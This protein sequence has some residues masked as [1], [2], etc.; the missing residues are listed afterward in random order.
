MKKISLIVLISISSYCT[1]QNLSGYVVDSLNR[2]IA[3]AS[4]MIQKIDSTYIGAVSSDTLGFFLFDRRPPGDLRLIAAHLNYIPYEM[5]V[6]DGIYDVGSLRMRGD[7]NTLSE[8]VI[9]VDRPNVIIR[10]GALSYDSKQILSQKSVSN[11]FDV[12]KETPGVIGDADRVELLGSREVKVV[13]NDNPV[14]M[15][16]EQVLM[17]LKSMPASRVKSVDIMYNAP[18]RYVNVNG[19]VINIVLDNETQKDQNVLTGEIGVEYQNQ[20]YSSGLIRTNLVYKTPRLS[21]DILANIGKGKYYSQD[22]LYSRYSISNSTFE[23]DQSSRTISDGESIDA[24][25]GVDYKLKREHNITFSYYF[26]LNNTRSEINSENMFPTIDKEDIFSLNNRDRSNQLHNALIKLYKPKKYNLGMELTYYNSPES[27]IFNEYN[28]DLIV[29]DYKNNS[30][31]EILRWIIFA[32]RSTKLKNWSINY[33]ANLGI[34]S[35]DNYVE[36]LFP[37]S[38][39]EYFEDQSKRVESKLDEITGNIFLSASGKIGNKITASATVKTEYFKTDYK[40]ADLKQT[41]WNE[42]SLF[43]S[44]TLTYN[45]SKKSIIQFNLSSSKSYPSYWAISPQSTQVNSYMIIE[46]NPELKP[47]KSYRTQLLYML[48]RKYIFTLFSAYSPDTFLQLPYQKDEV[49]IYRFENLDYTLNVGAGVVI[50]FKIGFWDSRATVQGFR[51]RQKMSNFYEKE[52]INQDF[53]VVAMLNNTFTISKSQPNIVLQAD[54]R[55]QSSAIQGIYSL[56]PAYNLS[57]SIKWTLKDGSYFIIRYNNILRQQ[58]PRPILVDWEGQYSRRVNR[59]YSSVVIAF[60]WQI[61]SYKKSNYDKVDD[62][63]FGR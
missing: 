28:N 25:V 26:N 24:R 44:A 14:S 30:S 63:R 46:G 58:T 19:A 51:M 3:F 41:L 21:L 16:N 40:L 56:G 52:F 23:V 5:V 55:Y 62:S 12:V 39:G 9:I 13:I 32:D 4:V 35:A 54:G 42:W 8:A 1:A 34:N 27:I 61:G 29:S 15:S 20:Y 37:N 57:S 49:T 60:S 11:A 50:P 53:V 45:A 6:K 48:N 33:G 59:E 2:P 10:D 7:L 17:L 31:Q 47:S 18:A 38:N 43:P 22:S 36:Y